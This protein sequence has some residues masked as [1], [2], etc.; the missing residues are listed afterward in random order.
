M[1]G[2]ALIRFYSY[3][4]TQPHK[5]IESVKLQSFHCFLGQLVVI[6]VARADTA[7]ERMLI[8]TIGRTVMLNRKHERLILP[9]PHLVFLGE[10]P[11]TSS[12]IYTVEYFIT[13]FLIHV[14]LI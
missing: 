1:G 6:E 2:K 3:N 4:W 11:G 14:K 9:N 10:P 8:P 13:S 5:T 7:E 12:G